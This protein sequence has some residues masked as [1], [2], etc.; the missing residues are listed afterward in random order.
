MILILNQ[1][2]YCDKN[3][4]HMYN[5][6]TIAINGLTVTVTS[7]QIYYGFVMYTG[8]IYPSVPYSFITNQLLVLEFVIFLVGYTYCKY[9]ESNHTMTYILN[10]GLV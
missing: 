4:G 2:S 7:I 5:M 6:V 10:H 3:K 1:S 9:I 8:S